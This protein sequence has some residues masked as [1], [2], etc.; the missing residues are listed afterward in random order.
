[1]QIQYECKNISRGIAMLHAGFKMFSKPSKFII[2]HTYILP[3]HYYCTKVLGNAC[4][5]LKPPAH[6]KKYALRLILSAHKLDHTAPITHFLS[7]LSTHDICTFKFLSLVY[8]ISHRMI[9]MSLT[10]DF[11]YVNE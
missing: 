6:L 5:S 10:Y 2:C 11:S 3:H 1:M 4:N 8:S 7:L 9:N